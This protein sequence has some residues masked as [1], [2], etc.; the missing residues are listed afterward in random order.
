M[1]TGN[2]RRTFSQGASR[3]ENKDH[4]LNEYIREVLG[5][6]NISRTINTMKINS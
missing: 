2:G 1:K 6:K 4:K 3:I 5:L